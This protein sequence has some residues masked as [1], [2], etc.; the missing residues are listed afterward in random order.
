MASRTTRKPARR[1]ATRCPVEP[2]TEGPPAYFDEETLRRV[3]SESM[4]DVLKGLGL[5]TNEP[6]EVQKDMAYLRTMR[7]VTQSTGIKMLMTGVW[8][9]TIGLIVALLIGL[10][11][12]AKF[13]TIFSFR[14][15]A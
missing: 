1:H 4:R 2:E 5:D 8:F 9:G 11:V 6:L 12:P 3:I 7:K 10:G 14:V 13:L 15:P